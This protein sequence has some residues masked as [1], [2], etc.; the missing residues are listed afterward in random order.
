MHQHSQLNA[1]NP[2]RFCVR[3][4]SVALAVS[5]WQPT[6]SNPFAFSLGGGSPCF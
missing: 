2:T 6:P 5:A 3:L 1:R 4:A